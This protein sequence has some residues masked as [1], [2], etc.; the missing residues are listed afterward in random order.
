LVETHTDHED[1]DRY[2]EDRPCKSQRR[3]PLSRPGFSG[4]PFD[5]GLL[6]VKGLGHRGVRLVTSGRAHTFVFV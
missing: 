1:I 3:T 4:N 6:V 5:S 2:A